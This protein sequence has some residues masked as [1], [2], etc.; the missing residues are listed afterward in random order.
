MANAESKFEFGPSQIGKTNFVF[1]ILT[2][3]AQSA[4]FLITWD[5][6]QVRDLSS[7]IPNLPW[8][9]YLPQFDFGFLLIGSLG[10]LLISPKHFGLL[11]HLVILLIAISTDQL[12]C[13][14]QVISV[15]VLMTACVFSKFK[16]VAVW[17]LIAMWFWAGLHKLL[18]PDW[19]GEVTYYM[20]LRKQFDWQTIRL[21]DYHL[22]FGIVVAIAEIGLGILA[23]RRPR[24]ASPL[25]FCTHI[26]IAIF[27]LLIDWNFSVLPWNICTAIVG[28]WLLWKFNDSGAS[29]SLPSSGLGKLAVLILLLMPIG[30]Y[31]GWVRHSL[32]H[33]L[34]SGNFPDAVITRGAGPQACEAIEILRVPFPHEQKAFIDFFRLT[35]QPGEKMHIREFRPNM[36]SRHFLMTEQNTVEEIS[37]G[38]FF[39]T[40]NGSLAGIEFDDRRKL[41]RLDKTFHTAN[42]D[43]TNDDPAVSRILKRKSGH[44]AWAI[45]FNPDTFKRSTLELLNGLPNLEQVQLSGCEVEDADLRHISGLKRL[46]GIGLNDTAITNSGLVYLKDL[47]ELKTIQADRT[48]ITQKSIERIIGKR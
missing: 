25:C 33:V 31:F 45:K 26:G 35:G 5:V 19:T 4:T 9:P 17:F 11:V 16:S 41:F 8:L 12:R 29:A 38:Q 34:Y 27:L 13:Q 48:S 32:S 6:W 20:L 21:W 22:M 30:F 1:L 40:Q 3:I 24:L 36:K 7:A 15:A 14:P 39:G 10:L 23:W 44:M 47:P 18:S 37:R 43:M 46:R 28:A 42:A 2:V